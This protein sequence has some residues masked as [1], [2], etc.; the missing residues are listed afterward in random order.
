MTHLEHTQQTSWFGKPMLVPICI[1][2]ITS[3]VGCGPEVAGDLTPSSTRSGV[4]N[5][6]EQVV[7]KEVINSGLSAAT[8]ALSETGFSPIDNNQTFDPLSA[9]STQSTTSTKSLRPQ[10]ATDA[11]G[12]I[13][14]EDWRTG[15]PVVVG[16][17]ALDNNLP[18]LTFQDID[19][20]TEMGAVAVT[21]V[22]RS[23]IWAG[24]EFGAI[25]FRAPG[26]E[27][28][29]ADLHQVLV[30]AKPSGRWSS[31]PFADSFDPSSDV[32]IPPA[33]KVNIYGQSGRLLSTLQMRDG[34][35]INDPALSQ[36]RKDPSKALRPF[37][38]CGMLLPWSSG[39]SRASTKVNKLFP[40]F[41][42]FPESRGKMHYSTNGAIPLLSTGADGRQQ[43]NGVNNWHAMPKWPLASA[44]TTDSTL[45][46]FGY[47]VSRI[48]TG[49]GPSARSAWITGWGYEPGSISGHDWFTGPGGVRFDRAVVPAPMA[50]FTTNP[51]YR[52][53]KDNAPIRELVESWGMA[54]FNHSGHYLTD[55]KDFSTILGSESDRNTASQ[56]GAYYGNGRT[57]APLNKSIDMRAITNG[58]YNLEGNNGG[59]SPTYYLDKNGNRF[60]NGWVVDDNHLH[61][62]P[63]WHTILMNSPM[64]LVASRAAFNQAHLARLGT[65][66]ITMR[67]TSNWNPGSSYGS[68][69]SRVQAYRWMHYT[70]MWKTATDHPLGISRAAVEK[71]FIDDLRK[72]HDNILQPT[73]AES[74]NPYHVA[75]KQLGVPVQAIEDPSTG[76]WFLK[77][78]ATPLQYYH[79]TLFVTLKSLGLWDTLRQDSKAKAA[80]DFVIE[81]MSKY[82]IDFITATEGRAENSDGPT[83]IAGPF[84]R[85]EDITAASVPTSW[86]DWSAKNP[87]L[88]Q[89]N[90]I[91]DS[92]GKLIERY[93]GQHLRAQWAFVMRDWYPEIGGSRASNGA[94]KYQSFYEQWGANV[95]SKPTALD[96]RNA[97][98]V[99]QTL[100]YSIVKPPR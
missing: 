62:T 34:K 97:D 6:T 28:S 42:P 7:S 24:F 79:A 5:S 57:F 35:P 23:I 66:D 12:A 74:R 63:Y 2:L 1:S 46:P 9:A 91:Q 49:E 17:V 54:Y 39:L 61:Q 65:R 56:M 60:W 88:G 31:Y 92:A 78:D 37:F 11:P 15:T 95:A 94:N 44:V 86:A 58:A 36:D 19:L 67:P 50:Y 59:T 64:H 10:D 14:L 84:N 82:S 16:K 99:F 75:F 40:G 83:T 68:V 76:K 45:D 53:P 43:L 22:K 25:A 20:S 81:S 71:A 100:P 52:R 13:E 8:A 32:T 73:L 29:G 72:W 33:F 87:K 4:I 69:N 26:L 96:Q 93:S 47:D 21:G 41:A 48:W 89:E 80:L 98:F 3:I 27:Q 18:V 77:T 70:L 90:W 38:N 30:G 55:V 51:N 85:F